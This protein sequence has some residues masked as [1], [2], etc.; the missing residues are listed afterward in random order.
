MQRNHDA[1]WETYSVQEIISIQLLNMIEEQAVYKF[2]IYS[3]NIDDIKE[4]LFVSSLL[5][6]HMVLILKAS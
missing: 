5:F 4:A 2:I 3:G 6:K 1:D